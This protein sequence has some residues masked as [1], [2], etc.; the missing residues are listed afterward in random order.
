MNND[1]YSIRELSKKGRKVNV[2]QVT[3]CTMFCEW[4]S[5]CYV[6]GSLH[7]ALA[8]DSLCYILSVCLD[9]W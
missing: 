6:L 3:S 9:M 8:S 2:S 4:H 7:Y 1:S 5:S